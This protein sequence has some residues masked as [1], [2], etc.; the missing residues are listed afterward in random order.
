VLSF[1][2]RLEPVVALLATD[3]VNLAFEQFE[4]VAVQ[5]QDWQAEHP[6]GDYPPGVRRM[7]FSDP[8]R[9]I[10]HVGR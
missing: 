2:E 8:W 3:G 5:A 1:W 9:D 10:D 6:R 4:Y 7:P